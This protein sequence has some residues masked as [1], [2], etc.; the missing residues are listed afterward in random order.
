MDARSSYDELCRRSRELALLGSC[1]SLLGWDEQTFMPSGGAE[2]RS[3]QV[4]LLA[5]LRHAQATDP[6]F[7]DLLAE[8][9]AAGPAA[10]GPEAAN[11][12]EWRRGYDRLVKLP[13]ALVEELARETSLAQQ[14]WVE[15][16]QRRDF[17]HF[18]H[19][20][21][22]IVN[23]K[24]REAHC[25]GFVD[26]PYD[27]LLDEY[28]PGARCGDLAVLFQGLRE[29]VVPLVTFIMDSGKRPNS[30]ILDRDYPIDRQ[31][32]FG[33]L[34]AATV[35]FDFTR[36]R[37]DTAAHPFCCGIGPGDTRLT[38]RYDPRDFTES[39]FG[40]L[41][42]T[43]HGLYDQGLDP[44]HEGTPLGEAVSL[45]VHE[46][47]SRLWENFVG[48]GRPF[49]DFAFPLARGFFPSALA[50]VT[51]DDLWFAINEVK[52]SL[53]RTQ[54]DEVT[55]NLH[56]MVRFELERAL[57]ADDLRVNEVPGA[58][59]EAYRR[60][61]GIAPAHDGEGCLQDIHWSAGLFG[62]FPTYTLG[63]LY[64]AQL[65]QAARRDLGDLDES[66]RRGDFRALLDWLRVRV[67]RLGQRHRPADLIAHATGQAP[68]HQFL[69]TA[70]NEKYRAIYS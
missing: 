19:A 23:L 64:A 2:H 5:G 41:H 21:G 69:V 29:A 66:A 55:Y 33:E 7:G 6:R 14:V 47:Q 34:V 30:T 8:V 50:G 26:V 15:A 61:L 51:L 9:E 44:E 53:I 16:R 56:I 43:G 18:R 68:D 60:D 63:N 52:P 25:L 45:G 31:R 49:W 11:V 42:E 28:E 40:I 10:E 37:L 22:T 57:L 70:L 67:H 20:L 46:S 13:R 65:F 32:L 1:G 36:G 27:A 24:R 17:G 39:F 48:R 35:G 54:A 58:W 59:E 62:Y 4:A 38:T 3:R 12:R